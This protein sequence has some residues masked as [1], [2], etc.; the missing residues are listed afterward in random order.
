M[1]GQRRAAFHFLGAFFHDHHGFVRFGL[2]GFD[3]GRDVLCGAAAVFRELAD[4]V[5][6][7]RETAARF[8][9]ARRLNGRVQRQQVG[10][11]GDVVDDVDDFRNFQRAVAKRFYFLGGGLHGGANALHAFQR[12]AHGAVA[13]L[14]GVQRAARCFR[15]GF[16]VVGHLFHRNGELFDGA[17]GVGDFL[18]LLRRAGLHFVGGNE[19]VIGA[20]GDFHGGFADALENFSEVVEHVVDGVRDVAERVVG[21]F[22]AQGQV[23]TRHLVDD[24][25]QLRDAAL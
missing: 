25:E 21:D 16:G 4:F 20:R 12:I 22:S 2:N 17:R 11:L 10:L 1:I 7:D 15:A 14:G 3:E 23:T 8:S 6:D 24:R 19:N 13:L 18:V 9:G 5:G